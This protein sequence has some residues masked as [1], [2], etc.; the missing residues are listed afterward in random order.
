[1]GAISGKKDDTERISDVYLDLKNLA[2][3]NDLDYIITA[4]HVKRDK[5]T[6]KR[7]STKYM[8]SDVAKSIDKTRH[9]DM[10]LGLQENDEEKESG[11]MRIEIVDQRDGT[12]GSCLFWIDIA[13]QYAKEFTKEQVKEYW[14]ETGREDDGKKRKPEKKSDI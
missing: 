4:S 2:V 14:A 11:V 8:S 1:M 9:C 7:R 5:D 12:E 3:E 6:L 10:I 13:K